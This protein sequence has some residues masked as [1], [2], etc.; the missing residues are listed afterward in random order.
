MLFI[1]EVNFFSISVKAGA[2]AFLMSDLYVGT[3]FAT[4]AE[5]DGISLL[6]IPP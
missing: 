4:S 5:S 3:R 6:V 2:V 1:G